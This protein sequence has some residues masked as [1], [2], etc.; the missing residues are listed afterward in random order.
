MGPRTRRRSLMRYFEIAYAVEARGPR[1][2]HASMTN[3]PPDSA[4]PNSSSGRPKPTADR[5]PWQPQ[6]WWL[7]FLVLMI[8]NYLLAQV[9]FPAPLSITVPYTFFKAQVEVGGRALLQ[10]QRV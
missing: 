4:A 3:L 7:I 2:A 8:A 1:E 5:A 6:P 9:F 10:P